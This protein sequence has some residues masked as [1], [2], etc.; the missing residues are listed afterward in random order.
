VHPS[1]GNDG[2]AVDGLD[3]CF[4]PKD[5]HTTA[6]PGQLIVDF[7]SWYYS[8]LPNKPQAWLDMIEQLKETP[9]VAL[10]PL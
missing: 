4:M 2:E 7:L 1:W 3:F 6:L 9:E 10:R 8:V 5:E